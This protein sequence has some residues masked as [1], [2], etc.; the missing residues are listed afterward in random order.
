MR[1][2]RGSQLVHADPASAAQV[3]AAHRTLLDFAEV[4]ANE[5]EFEERLLAQPTWVVAR[6]AA[7]LSA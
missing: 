7:A 5:R 4:A 6:I 2:R 1:S 3:P